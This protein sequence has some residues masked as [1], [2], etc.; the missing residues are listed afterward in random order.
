MDRLERVRRDGFSTSHDEAARGV[1]AIAVAVA[2][3]TTGEEASLCIVFPASTTDET[4][5][6]AIIAA[7]SEQAALVNGRTGGRL[8]A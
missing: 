2:D 4:E 8:A 7:L 6:R 3:E 5:R 1:S